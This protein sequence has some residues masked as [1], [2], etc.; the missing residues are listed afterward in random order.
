MEGD[1]FKAEAFMFL[2]FLFYELVPRVSLRWRYSPYRLL[3]IK[4]GQGKKLPDLSRFLR[5]LLLILFS[6]QTVLQRNPPTSKERDLG[7]PS[8]SEFPRGSGGTRNPS[9]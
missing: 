3:R 9:C 2:I 1:S 7:G 5:Y 4:I 8:L 6:G